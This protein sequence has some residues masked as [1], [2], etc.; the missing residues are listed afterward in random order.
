MR[1]TDSK[2]HW[3]QSLALAALFL[4]SDAALALPEDRDQ[5]MTIQADQGA[6]RSGSGEAHFQGNVHL[7]Q[8][9]LEVWAET[10]DVTR[11]PVT[12]VIQFLEARGEPARYQEQP[13]VDAAF[14][15]VEG[16]RIE[17]RPQQDIIITEGNGRLKQE[18]SEIQAEYIQYNLLDET[19]SVRSVRTQTANPEAPQATWVIQ[20][21]AVD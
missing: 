3:R 2:R 10:L 1:P 21:G 18:G 12:G 5:P 16:L 14:I 8:G 11:D 7:Q 19:L 20:P 13:D 17:Y 4:L 15:E 9:S 6:F